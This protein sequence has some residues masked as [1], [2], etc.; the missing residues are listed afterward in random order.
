MGGSGAVI[1]A[2]VRGVEKR[3]RGT[4][5]LRCRVAAILEEGGRAAGVRLARGGAGGGAERVVRA[6]RAVV[7]NAPIWDTARLLDAAASPA[8]RAWRGE[9]LAT[10]PTDSFTHLHVGIDGAGLP[11]D[12]DCHHSVIFD[13]AREGG[14]EARENM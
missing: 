9:V 3:G 8:V 12:L 2:L 4:V 14:I 13:L 10:P 1:D 7:S 6:R 5:A 11:D